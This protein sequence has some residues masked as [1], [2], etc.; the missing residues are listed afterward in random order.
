MVARNVNNGE[1]K[2]YG[3]CQS[4]INSEDYCFIFSIAFCVL[5]EDNGPPVE[6]T[7]GVRRV[8]VVYYTA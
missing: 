8:K 3:L 5:C 7:R 4:V 1:K 2:I 6:T